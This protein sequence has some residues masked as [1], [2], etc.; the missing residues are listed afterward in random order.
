M[1]TPFK[2][3]V[4]V[5]LIL[6]SALMMDILVSLELF[7]LLTGLVT[8]RRTRY[9]RIS[10]FPNQLTRISRKQRCTLCRVTSTAM[11]FTCGAILGRSGL[12]LVMRTYR[13]TGVATRNEKRRNLGLIE[14]LALSHV[15]WASTTK[16]QMENSG[17]A[18]R[19][20]HWNLPV[21]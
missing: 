7:P 8:L 12:E 9:R 5:K 19:L 6:S 11:L 16:R 20:V 17:E 10:G 18:G 21:I 13:K 1:V 3:L 2:A 4:P 14:I 15:V